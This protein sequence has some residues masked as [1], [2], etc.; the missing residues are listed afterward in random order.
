[1][2]KVLLNLTLPHMLK[3]HEIEEMLR[4]EMKSHRD[5]HSEK[6]FEMEELLK[7]TRDDG[8]RRMEELQ[9]MLKD[10]HSEKM[11]AMKKLIEQQLR[12]EHAGVLESHFRRLRRCFE[13]K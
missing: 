2:N 5:S 11:N 6:L 3:E 9:D 7:E 13:K 10:E 1:M 4:E 12:D 8:A